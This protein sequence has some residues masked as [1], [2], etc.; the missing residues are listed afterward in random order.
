MGFNVAYP[1]YKQSDEDWLGDVPSTWE[2]KMIKHLSPVKRGASPRPI[3][4]PKYF[5]DENGEY[6]WVRIADVTASNSYLHHTTQ[7]MSK[8][9]S[10][11]SVKLEPNQL[12]LSIAGTVGKPCINKIKVCIHDGFVYF[13]DLSIPHKFLYYVF[14]GEQ[15]Y[16]GLGKMGT[17]LNLNTDTVGSIKV[18]LPKDEI[19]IQGIIDFLDHETAKI[20]TLI[21]KQQQ[22]IKLLKEKR[23]A[24]ISHAVTK[25]LNPYAPMKDSGV[26][27][28]GEVPEHWSPATPIKYLSSLKGRL[29]WQGLKA[30]EYKDDG[31]HVVSSAHF[32]NH[33]INWG[34]CPRVSEERYELDS[35]IQLES[36]DILLMKDG[37]AMGKLAYVDDLPGKACLNSHLLLF[38]PL[39]RDDIKTFHTKF[40]FYLMQT[41]HFQGFIRNNGTGA[42]FLGIS[43]QAIG[44]HRL[45]LPDYEE[46][47]SIAKFLDEQVSKLSALENKKNQMMALLFERRAA[48][49]S[50][51][52]T[53]KI[54][55]RNWKPIDNKNT[56]KVEVTA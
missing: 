11:L 56:E 13:P 41:E 27:W 30:D 29:G 12:F 38:R 21:E 18:A 48:L 16:K 39:L 4:D 33:E 1:E 49:I 31:P 45:I 23:Q 25:G 22:L 36:G 9:G 28:L 24:V 14:A 5:D 3:D 10:S 50:A 42:T 26:E 53:G 44:N 51:A 19:E 2:I 34:M 52:V 55:V 40:M 35:N 32:N 8:I 15:A 17:Q 46:Q 37:A 7:K 54:D 43:Q 6:A 47:L 20:D